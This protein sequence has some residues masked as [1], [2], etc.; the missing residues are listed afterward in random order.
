MAS[1][2]ESSAEVYTERDGQPRRQETW[3]KVAGA[4]KLQESHDVAA[5]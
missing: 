2:T 3:I 5:R 4:W 1:T